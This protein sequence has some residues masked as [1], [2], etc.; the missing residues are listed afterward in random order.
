M[1]GFLRFIISKKNISKKSLSFFLILS[2]SFIPSMAQNLIKG[3]VIDSKTSEGMPFANVH[4]SNSTKG[5]QTDQN[6]YFQLHNVPLGTIQLLVSYVGYESFGQTLKMEANTQMEL[7]VRIIP[8]EKVFSEIEIKSK[9]DKS[10]EKTLKTFKRTFL[11]LNND[12]SKCK[13]LNEWVIDFKDVS[14]GFSANSLAPIEI[15]NRSLGYKVYYDLKEFVQKRDNS[16]FYLGYPRF[17]E[18]T[19]NDKKEYN[20]WLL[21]RGEVYLRSQE[22]FYKS[23]Y[24]GSLE[25]DGYVVFEMDSQSEWYLSGKKFHKAT[26]IIDDKNLAKRIIVEDQKNKILRLNNPIEI[27]NSKISTT[28]DARL[29]SVNGGLAEILEDG[30]INNPRALEVGGFW[31]AQGISELLPREYGKSESADYQMPQSQKNTKGKVYLH[32]NKPGYVTGENVWFSA[33]IFDAD[34]KVSRKPMPIYVQLHNDMGEWVAEQII[35]SSNGRGVGYLHL[36]DS[37]QSGVYRIRAYNREMLNHPTTIFDKQLVVQNPDDAYFVK[38]NSLKLEETELSKL[39]LNVEASNDAFSPNEN[40]TVKLKLNNNFGEP[41]IASLSTS[42]IN[43]AYLVAEEED[44]NINSYVSKDNQKPETIGSFFAYEPNISITGKVF[45]IKT[46]KNIPNAKVIFVF[47]GTEATT[48]SLIEADKNGQFRISDLGFIGKNVLVYQVNS[49]KNEPLENCIV[50]IDKFPVAMQIAPTVS[51]K[52]EWSQQKKEVFKWQQKYPDGI[53]EQQKIEIPIAESDGPE[54]EPESSSPGVTKIYGEPDYYVNFERQMN[55]TNVYEMLQG[56]L[57]GVK[58]EKTVNMYKV[59]VR[60][61]GSANTNQLDPLFL[62]DG[63]E[64][65]DL[66]SVNPN[67]IIRIELLS[68][69]KAAIFGMKGSNGVIA[70]YTRRFAEKKAGLQYT[71]NEVIN[72]YQ[73]EID[74]K[75]L[76]IQQ[77]DSSPILDFRSTIY[78]NPEIILNAKGEG[79]FTFK[80]PKTPAKLK[81]I[82][83]GVTLFGFTVRKEFN[84]QVKE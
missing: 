23:L 17:E 12:E 84:I 15:E 9:R 70:F 21:N 22:R 68:G 14:G 66:S 8:N 73:K 61:I 65:T 63:V 24:H 10:W 64:M 39:V 77:I 80:A 57:P 46:Q 7:T 19:P 42:V 60:G 56:N 13:I 3:K 82:I 41:V 28:I 30:W 79:Q 78:W 49:K 71:K 81:V 5:T 36:P 27:L 83:E 34:K 37:L 2:L 33:Y 47:T 29:K 52:T 50:L 51:Q 18:I 32:T 62:V 31:A 26:N 58:V 69:G 25:K 75:Q 40:I 11:G 72:G 74:F 48:T 59:F 6:G 16:F 45:D 20:K 55:F 53:V 76:D 43:P 35:F 4:I 38:R 67:D 1:K 44:F 54:K